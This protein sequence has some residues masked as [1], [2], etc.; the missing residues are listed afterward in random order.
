[1]KTPE[2]APSDDEV[3][4]VTDVVF[5]IVAGMDGDPHQQPE[6]WAYAEKI[7]RE[8]I[9]ALPPRPADDTQ[10]LRDLLAVI[11]RDGGHKT[12]EIGVKASVAL[13][14][15]KWGALITASDDVAKLRE[16]LDAEDAY[17]AASRALAA[18]LPRLREQPR[19]AFEAAT[20]RRDE[21]R[22]ALTPTKD[23]GNG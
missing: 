7:A 23:N 12:A 18:A 13:A 5:R 22:A 15:E 6:T 16:A 11:H 20:R 10:A 4:R 2:R 14:R 8:T 3:E 1:M 9:A 17:W 21:A 19:V